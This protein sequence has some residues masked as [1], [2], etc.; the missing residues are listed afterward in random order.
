M[1]TQFHERLE[2]IEHDLLSLGELSATAVQRAV[3]SFVERDDALATDVIAADDAIDEQYLAIDHGTLSVVALQAPVAADLRLV[4]A[5]LHS[6]LHLERMGDQAVNIAKIQLRT[7]ALPTSSGMLA[8]IDEM[9]DLVVQMIRIALEAFA[10]RDVG[11][12]EQLQ[13]L[14]DPVDRLNRATH[15]EAL[16]LAE[17][18]PALDWGL[19]ANLAARA[20]ERVGDQAVDIGEQVAYLVTG[21]FR[22]FTDASHKVEP[23]KSER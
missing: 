13:K 19:H 20:L 6:C 2:R 15:I 5:I 7:T 17:D 23:R 3:R 11:R 1:R 18:P 12:A 14:D 4:S 22:E 21:E 8:Q 9:G 16:K 10:H